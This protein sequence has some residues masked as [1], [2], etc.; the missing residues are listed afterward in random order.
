MTAFTQFKKYL[1]EKK[2]GSKYKVSE[3]VCFLHPQNHGRVQTHV[4]MCGQAEIQLYIKKKILTYSLYLFQRSQKDTGLEST[5]MQRPIQKGL[6]HTGIYL[7][8][9]GG[10]SNVPKH[11][12]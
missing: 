1:Y 5:L 6:H 8:G 3:C 4:H 2:N 12:G 7:S 11:N 10:I 9:S